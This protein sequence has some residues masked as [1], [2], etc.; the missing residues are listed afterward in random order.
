MRR[1]SVWA[2]AGAVVL[3]G[4]VP[5]ARAEG[6]DLTG[7][8]APEI[9]VQE[10]IQGI[11]TGTSLSSCRG[12]V[13][14]LK[15]WFTRCPACIRSLPEFQSLYQRYSPRGVQFVAIAYDQASRVVPFLRSGGYTFPVAI[16][17]AGVTSTRYGVFTYPTTYVI[18]ADGVVKAYDQLSAALIERELEAA[19][20]ATR[21][22]AGRRPL[23]TFP[24]SAAAPPAVAPPSFAP[25]SLA[26][27]G[28]AYADPA[29]PTGTPVAVSAMAAEPA[30]VPSPT[31][32]VPVAEAPAEALA[33]HAADAA[34]GAAPVPAMVR[35]DSLPADPDLA[36]AAPETTTPPPP[37][38]RVLSG[39]VS[40]SAPA[41]GVASSHRSDLG[42]PPDRMGAAVPPAALAPAEGIEVDRVTPVRTDA[43]V[44]APAALAGAA[45]AIEVGD[46]PAAL[47]AIEAYASTRTDLAAW[48]PFDLEE[49]RRLEGLVR[50][51]YLRRHASISARWRRH[52]LLPAVDAARALATDY[53]GTGL[54]RVA[55][56]LAQ[57]Y[58]SHLPAAAVAR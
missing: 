42:V 5:R 36:V 12:Q 9:H 11:A 21:P 30:H 3:L 18:G 7:Q 31:S 58:E 1:L 26:G 40:P 4:S 2:L 50:E 24:R 23:L 48:S 13:V 54:E 20:S 15:F 44:A 43:S 35:S 37:S 25:P 41:G 39:S 52:E 57:W 6:N 38:G 53:R 14:V 22:G 46:F 34:L 55:S 8:R 27:G 51:E 49:A 45:S 29:T 47:R 17:S 28:P 16:D 56:T 33:A 10:G 32:A 19:R